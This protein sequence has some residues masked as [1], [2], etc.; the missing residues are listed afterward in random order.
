M[1]TDVIGLKLWPG[2]PD[3][4]DLGTD[5][6][7][8]AAASPRDRAGRGRRRRDLGHRRVRRLQSAG[9]F[10]A[11][12]SQSQQEASLAARAFGRD[13]GDV[14]V[15]YSSRVLTVRDAAF[16]SAVTGTLAAL[17]RSRVESAAT[18]WSTGSPQFVSASGRETYA[19]IELTG[20]SDSA[21]I[22]ASTRSRA[23]WP[24]PA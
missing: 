14:V 4:R 11:P 1:F 22:R 23:T 5:R 7:P 6:L 3:V 13:S 21:R 20:G 12:G 2:D 17:P 8:A 19:V 24:R 15:L 18:Y 10:D 16:R 9:G